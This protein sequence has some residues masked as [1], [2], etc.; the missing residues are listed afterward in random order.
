[1]TVTLLIQCHPLRTAKTRWGKKGEVFLTNKYAAKL[2]RDFTIHITNPSGLIIMGREKELT[3]EQQ[4]DFEVI[5]RQYKNVVDIITYDD[6][7]RRLEFMIS[8]LKGAK[9][10]PN[11]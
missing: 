6:L 10:S 8:Q 9:V 2:P 1:M 3:T 4:R 5:K 7:I 11:E